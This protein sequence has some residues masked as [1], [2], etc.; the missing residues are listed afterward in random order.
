MNEES[1]YS[2]VVV[3]PVSFLFL[4]VVAF[5]RTSSSFRVCRAA[6]STQVEGVHKRTA[7]EEAFV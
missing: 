7:C 6:Q 5:D 1:T 4:C 3:Q 2:S